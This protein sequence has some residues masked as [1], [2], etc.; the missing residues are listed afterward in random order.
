MILQ[1][2]DQI[3]RV[4]PVALGQR[5][6]PPP[7]LVR[8]ER[9]LRERDDIG[10]DRKGGTPA[11]LFSSRFA[12]FAGRQESRPSVGE[13]HQ[14]LEPVADHVEVRQ[15]VLEGQDFPVGEEQG[16]EMGDG[17][18]ELG[19]STTPISDLRSPISGSQ[20]RFQ[21]LLK[22]FLGAQRLGDNQQRAT[23]KPTLEQGG[24][25]GLRGSRHTGQRQCAALL[26]ALAQ[27]LHRGSFN[28]GLDDAGNR[29]LRLGGQSGANVA[30]KAA[31][32]KTRRPTR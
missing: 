27:G 1:P 32:V 6:H 18:W 9:P 11:A 31:G 20:P 16:S 25:G 2:L 28:Q 19:V 7:Q 4:Q 17:R 15:L 30:G 22:L 5:L 21:I 29:A 3:E 24:N 8:C 10:D 12:P 13:R 26:D 23:G 14:R